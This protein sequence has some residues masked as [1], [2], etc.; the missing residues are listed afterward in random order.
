MKCPYCGSL[1][2]RVVDSRESRDGDSIRRRRQCLN[3][4]RRFTSYERT[5][6]I[7]YMVVKKDGGRERFDRGKIL[8]GLMTACEKR[9]VGLSILEKI[10]DRVET[11]VQENPER[12]LESAMIG[13]TLLSELRLLDKVA[14]LRFASVYLAFEDVGEFMTEINDLFKK[15]GTQCR[16]ERTSLRAAAGA[17]VKTRSLNIL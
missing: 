2:D 9:P 14:Y 5:D 4:A 16:L 3:C 1:K 6:D 17:R 12:E 13:K 15:N 8:K 11:M 10:V 7:P